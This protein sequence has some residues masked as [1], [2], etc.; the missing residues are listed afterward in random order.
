MGIEV[1]P[2]NQ[3]SNQRLYNSRPFPL[4]SDEGDPIMVNSRFSKGCFLYVASLFMA[5]VGAVHAQE[6]PTRS[7]R[8]VVPYSAGGGTDVF[9]RIIAKKLS[10]RL[11]QQ[12][13]VDNRAGAGGIIGTEIVAQAPHDGYTMLMLANTHALYPSFYKK[14]PFDPI[15]SF[16][17]VTQVAF[18]PNVL[19][20]H[21]SLP[22]QTVGQLLALARH[23]PGELA[24]GSA[25]T[26]STTHL[27]GELFKSLAKINVVHVPYKGS[28]QAEID[29]AGG[30][31]QYMIDSVPAALPN[32]KAGRTRAIATTGRNRSPALPD[33]PTIAASGLPKYELSTW[34][35]IMVPAGTPDPVIL[36]LNKAIVETM[37]LPDVKEFL[38]GQ[39]AEPRTTSPQEFM[40]YIKTQTDFY[41]KIVADAGIKPQ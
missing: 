1:K 29:L 22:V 14:L 34:W 5:C 13:V 18:G 33:V 10:E 27:A 15:K 11:G 28:G 38:A 20:V 19:V 6:Y 30:Q 4:T 39:G 16:G 21:P 3:T 25:G 24:F 32:L 31:V 2:T 36:K 8:I 26:G 7:I 35:G 41:R 37:T 23:R 40:E 9:G 12:V 17:A